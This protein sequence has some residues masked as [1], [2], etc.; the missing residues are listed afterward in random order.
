M[1]SLKEPM[2]HFHRLATEYGGWYQD[3]SKGKRNTLNFQSWIARHRALANEHFEDLRRVA[4]AKHWDADH[5]LHEVFQLMAI[6]GHYFGDVSKAPCYQTVVRTSDLKVVPPPWAPLV[7][8]DP[9]AEG[10]ETTG[11]RASSLRN[12]SK[13]L[14]AIP[15][16][17]NSC[18][19]CGEDQGDGSWSRGFLVVLD[20]TQTQ[21][22][23]V[24]RAEGCATVLDWA[25]IEQYRRDGEKGFQ[26]LTCRNSLCTRCG[27]PQ[28]SVINRYARQAY[29]AVATAVAPTTQGIAPYRRAAHRKGFKERTLED[30]HIP[31][32]LKEFEKAGLLG[33]GPGDDHDADSD[34]DDGVLLLPAGPQNDAN[35]KRQTRA[36]AP[37]DESEY[38]L[39]HVLRLKHERQRARGGLARRL[40]F[41]GVH[42]EEPTDAWFVQ[43]NRDVY[44]ATARFA[45]RWFGDVDFPA[46]FAGAAWLEDYGVQFAEYT[47]RVACEDR[48]KAPWETMMRDKEHR[49]WLVVGVLSNII[50]K[51]IFSELLFGAT[52]DQAAELDKQDAMFVDADGEFP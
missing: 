30:V 26:C 36:D 28:A 17:I 46:D 7:S 23:R 12:G 51:K 15:T 29:Q 24:C 14:S 25:S 1:E 13:S 10:K 40:D 3:M 43:R 37:L 6:K 19:H 20:G 34:D 32:S 21:P 2:P 50:H 16:L 39:A 48:V 11:R 4:V 27:A 42:Q 35:K 18:E 38:N 41:R 5:F 52:K 8:P 22:T 49:K 31:L 47:S 9:C 45:E 44:A 33:D